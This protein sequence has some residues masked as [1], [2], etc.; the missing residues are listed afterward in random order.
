VTVDVEV[1]VVVG[2]GVTVEVGVWVCVED[3]V[4]EGVIV[5]V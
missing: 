4:S 2:C 1:G 3:G 5:A